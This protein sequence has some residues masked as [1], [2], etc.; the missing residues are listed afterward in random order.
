MLHK[1]QHSQTVYQNNSFIMQV[2]ARYALSES[3]LVLISNLFNFTD[4]W[5]NL[6]K[7]SGSS[8]LNHLLYQQCIEES[9]RQGCP[10]KFNTLETLTLTSP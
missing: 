4:L 3:S 7:E 9:F 10:A 8:T 1:S 5:S 6:F 2:G